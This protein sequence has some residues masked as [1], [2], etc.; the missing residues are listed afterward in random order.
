[1]EQ[2]IVRETV[3]HVFTAKELGEIASALAEAQQKM[4]EAEE[5]K[6]TVTAEFAASIKKHK[7][8]AN[9]YARKYANKFEMR[10][11][12]CYLVENISNESIDIIRKD[13]NEYVR[14]RPMTEEEIKKARQI[15]I[16]LEPKDAA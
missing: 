1:M 5:T 6:A 16:D 2:R 15:K 11:E 7:G 13:N 3:K 9:L 10:T 8:D 14:S 12:D 4:V